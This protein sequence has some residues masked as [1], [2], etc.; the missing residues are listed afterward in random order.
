[1]FAIRSVNLGFTNNTRE[2]AMSMLRF[3]NEML[4]LVA[5]LGTLYAWTLFGHALGL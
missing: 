2:I 1:M 3:L 5:L 4:T